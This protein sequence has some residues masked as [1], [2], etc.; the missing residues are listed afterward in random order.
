MGQKGNT[1]YIESEQITVFIYLNRA[2]INFSQDVEIYHNGVLTVRRRP[3]TTEQI[4]YKSIGARGDPFYIFE[5]CM[6]SVPKNGRIALDVK[7]GQFVN[8][9]Q[10]W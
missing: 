5:D 6:A 10:I 7:T 1:F 4:V 2:M 3:Q 8:S 9:G